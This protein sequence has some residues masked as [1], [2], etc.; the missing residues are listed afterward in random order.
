MPKPGEI[1]IPFDERKIDAMRKFPIGSGGSFEEEL[2][3]ATENLYKKL[4][5]DTVRYLFGDD[6]PTP[7]IPPD[8]SI[9]RAT[10]RTSL[11]SMP[12]CTRSLRHSGQGIYDAHRV[13]APSVTI[14]LN[15]VKAV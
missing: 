14:R 9:R 10:W 4:V 8:R 12:P 1:I 3:S 15:R 13:P 7:A 11:R 2:L 5:L 6:V